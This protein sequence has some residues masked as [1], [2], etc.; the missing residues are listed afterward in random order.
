MKRAN[1]LRSVL[2][3]VGRPFGLQQQR[4]N[5]TS[6]WIKMI[7]GIGLGAGLMYIFDPV[8]GARRRALARDK[9]VHLANKAGCALNKVSRDLSNRAYGL[10][11]ETRSLLRKEDLIDD[12]L[13]ARVRSKLGRV[14]THPNW[15]EVYADQGKITLKG[16][17]LAS[18]EKDLIKA[19]FSVK[20]VK[21]VE[22]F[23][24]TYQHEEEIPA[25]QFLKKQTTELP[26][27][28]EN[29]TPQ[30]RRASAR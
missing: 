30:V 19:V 26:Q 23:L 14:C 3:S 10:V 18:E 17:V 16:Q 9:I 29:E 4:T 11:A 24:T 20:G 15:I 25:R 12:V 7:V 13:V 22:N 6:E 27:T 28:M 5:S 1:R 8:R 2:N 21:G